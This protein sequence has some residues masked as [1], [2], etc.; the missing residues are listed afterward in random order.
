MF[1]NT[2]ALVLREVKYKEADRIL[3]L[4]TQSD[5]KMT[6]K[7][8]GALR[9][10]SKT[11]AA[12]QIYSYSEMTLLERNG[13]FTVSEASTIEEF[14][15][16]RSDLTLL[17]LANYFSECVESLAQEG[18]PDPEMLQLILNS[19]YA[20]S[21]QLYDSLVIKS[22]FE[23]RLMCISGYSPDLTGCSE[24]GDPAPQDP[25]FF[26]ATGHVCCD[27]CRRGI[28]ED[29]IRLPGES[30]SAMRYLTCADPKKLFS[31]PVEGTALKN[32]AAATERYLVCCT[33]KHYESLE[34]WKRINI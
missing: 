27:R 2:N 21:R 12:T 5:G 20:L 13:R 4:L 8:R 14:K 16:L 1:K 10:G 22:A 29:Y 11:G 15:G 3:T 23:M 28:T 33:E 19:Y 32:L 25:V 26:P 7:A 24:C 6:V 18:V 17:A 9:K 31:F 30:F 34:Y